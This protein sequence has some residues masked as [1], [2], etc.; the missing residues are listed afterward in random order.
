MPKG[1]KL[2]VGIPLL[3][4]GMLMAAGMGLVLS[5]LG[6]D[7]RLSS[8]ELRAS[9]QGVAIVADD[10]PL[11][12]F[13]E[14]RDAFTQLQAM[15][16]LDFGS[17]SGSGSDG[18]FL[19]IAPAS[20]ARD[21][22][23]DAPID[24]VTDFDPFGIAQT[25][26]RPGSGDVGPPG[27]QDFWVTTSEGGRPLSWTLLPGEWWLVVMNADGSA[28]VEVAGT[29]SVHVPALTVVVVI[30]LIV[31]LG[32]LAGGI[33]FVISATRMHPRI[34]RDAPPPPPPPLVGSRVAPPRPDAFG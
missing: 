32:L 21:Y 28:G 11:D 18:I 23:E 13:P 10:I 24:R 27:A 17:G 5:L 16:E 30:F 4:I 6:V 2:V 26:S 7:G 14:A 3:L 12:E 20:Q 25:A 15:V 29:A 34:R 8:P 31:G 19:G 22:L 33:F 9:S 1:L